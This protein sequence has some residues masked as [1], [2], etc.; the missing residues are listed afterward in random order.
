MIVIPSILKV[1]TQPTLRPFFFVLLHADF[2]L[3]YQLTQK[4]KKFHLKRR[5]EEMKAAKNANR[6]DKRNTFLKA[7]ADE[8][9]LDMETQDC[10]V[11]G[12]CSVWLHAVMPG[13]LHV[14]VCARTCLSGR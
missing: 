3:A 9:H 10:S 12:G 8:Y 14:C 13:W 1:T 6:T 7:C 11:S 5:S 2:V 4:E